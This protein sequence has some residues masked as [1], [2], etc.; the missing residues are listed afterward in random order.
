LRCRVP[1]VGWRT[2]VKFELDGFL[3]IGTDWVVH[4]VLR[5]ARSL[6]VQ[7]PDDREV[8]HLMTVTHHQPPREEPSA[9]Q[10]P[11]S[12]RADRAHNSCDTRLLTRQPTLE[13]AR[14]E[15]SKS[16]ETALGTE[17]ALE[18]ANSAVHRALLRQSRMPAPEHRHNNLRG[19]IR[20]LTNDVPCQFRAVIAIPGALDRHNRTPFLI[21]CV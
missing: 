4:W 20:A 15:I 13:V 18:S 21:N 2:I 11:E 10:H 9:L 7:E 19:I 5:I 14:W 3:I 17:D 16:E 8:N 6:L 1:R 12:E